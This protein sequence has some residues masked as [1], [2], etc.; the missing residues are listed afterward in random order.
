MTPARPTGPIILALDVGVAPVN[1]YA[2][3]PDDSAHQAHVV[4]PERPQTWAA[5]LRGSV[6]RL[7]AGL[8]PLASPFAGEPAIPTHHERP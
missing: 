3:P 8:H 2:D 1:R 4:L 7:V 5:E 6:P